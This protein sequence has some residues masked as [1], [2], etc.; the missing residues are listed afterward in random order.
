MDALTQR[1]LNRIEE[2]TNFTNPAL[3]PLLVGHTKKAFAL[4]AA[5]VAIAK[6]AEELG[7]DP[8]EVTKAVDGL[9]REFGEFASPATQE[10]KDRI[11]A[12]VN[13][14][15]DDEDA[16]MET[17]IEGYFAADFDLETSFNET[18]AGVDAILAGG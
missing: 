13:E 6:R 2:R 12:F 15:V 8:V 3:K 11:K 18:N 10:R 16:E 9:A 1:S 7:K 5:S 14:I 17:L 4:A